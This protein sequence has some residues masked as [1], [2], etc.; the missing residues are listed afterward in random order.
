M[1]PG[2]NPQGANDF[3]CRPREGERPV[4]LVPGTKEDAFATWSFYAP[5]LR[6]DGW[7]VF[8]FNY[9]PSYD[10]AGNLVDRFARRVARN[11]T[12]EGYLPCVS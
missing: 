11:I 12:F 10:L 4:V 1:T 9:N 3:S 2:L 6:R 8:T 7:C 5:S